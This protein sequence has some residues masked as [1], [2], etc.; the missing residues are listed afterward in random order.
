MVMIDEQRKA[1][2][3]E[4]RLRDTRIARLSTCD[5]QGRPHVVPVCYVYDGD[6]FFTP[7][8]RKP[9]RAGGSELTRVRNIRANPNVSLLLDHYDED[10]SKLWYIL[11]RGRAEIFSSGEEHAKPLALLREKYAQYQSR[12]LLP[13]EA[14][15]IRIV[16]FKIVS[17][18]R[19]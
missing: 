6:A 16:P 19:G 11:I 18:G 17:W 5:A 12:E 10:W 3:I 7:I 13:D 14:T 1:K 2:E 4:A 9:K 15:V 8:D